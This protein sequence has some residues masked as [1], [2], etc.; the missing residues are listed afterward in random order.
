MREGGQASDLEPRTGS[1]WSIR[2]RGAANTPNVNM[3]RSHLVLF[4]ALIALGSAPLHGV[5][6]GTVSGVV[7][8][9]SGVPQIGAEVELLRPD[10]TVIAS[11]YTNTTGHY[12]I[13][14]VVPGHYAVKALG[15]SFLPSLREN[16]RVRSSAVVNLTLNTLYEV[17]QWLPSAPRTAKAEQDDWKW[18]LRSAANRPLLRWLEDGPLVVVSDGSAGAHKLKA[19]LVATGQQGSFGESGERVSVAL[20]E[21]PANS[22]ELLAQVDFDPSSSA[23]MESM[24]GFRQDLGFVGAV[25]SV[26]AVAIHPEIGAGASDGLDEAAFRSSETIE[27]GD[28][29]EAEVGSAQVFAR[30]SRNSVNTVAAA[31]PFASVARRDGN[32]TVS[33]RMATA[34]PA[35]PELGGTAAQAWLPALSMRNGQ[36]AME[37]GLHQEIGW[38]RRTDDSD[39]SVVLFNDRIDNPIMEGGYR[40]EADSLTASAPAQLLIDPSSGLVRA[41]GPG[42]SSTGVQA[43]IEHR[44]PAGNRVRVSYANGNALVLAAPLQAAGLVQVLG[45]ARPRRAQSYSISL[46]GTLDGSSTRW[47]AT[48]RWQP[49]TTITSIASFSQNAAEPYLNFQ[50]RQPIHLHGD[51]ANGFEAVLD[52]RNLLAQGYQPYL[53]SDGSVLVFAQGQR[54][55]SG[56]LAFNF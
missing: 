20:E 8:D 49:E 34:V 26:A 4:A 15:T 56:G 55:I 19:R 42:F 30:F 17:M 11:V 37:H 2:A 45:S 53:L 9:S 40:P 52:L 3:S 48:Y 29:W 7:R 35:S 47:R 39:V 50:M 16:V 41:A 33:Y 25:E 43:A 46:S 54:G 44:L 38:E 51:G 10:L 1:F 13:P 28:E 21:T 6:P 24:L 27:L 31:L 18:T 36:L 22:R 23:G 5:A 32:S 14:S 12:A